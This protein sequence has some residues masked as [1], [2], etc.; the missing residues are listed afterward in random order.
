MQIKVSK[1][2]AFNPVKVELL[3]ESQAEVNALFAVGNTSRKT[4]A[5]IQLNSSTVMHKCEL[6]TVL[7]SLWK[8]LRD[9]KE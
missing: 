8:S 3:L 1:D 7:D 2:S 5:I 9:Y 4:R 6:D